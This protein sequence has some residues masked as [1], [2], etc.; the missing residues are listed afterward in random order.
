MSQ[1]NGAIYRLRLVSR[2]FW[3]ACILELFERLAYFGVRAIVPLYLVQARADRGLGLDFREKGIIFS[4]WALL[5]CTVP[6]VSGAL[7]D[8]YGHRKSLGVAFAFAAAGYVSMAQCEAIATR[9]SPAGGIG[10]VFVVFLVAASLVAIGTAIFKPAVQGTIAH[11]TPGE[12]SSLCW[13]VFYWIVNVGAA[14][15]PMC[16]AVLRSDTAWSNV[17]YAAA[18]VTGVNFLFALVFFQESI[19]LETRSRGCHR[20]PILRVVAASFHTI[21]RDK[22]LLF[23][24]AC[25]S[26]F[27]LMFMQVW[28]L[29][30]NFIN[31]WVDTSGLAPFYGWIHSGWVQANGQVK[32]ELIVNVNAISILLFVIPV[33]W[34]IAGFGKVRSMVLGMGLCVIGFVGCGTTP[35]GWLCCAMLFVFSV[36]EMI[37][38]PTFVAYIGLMA[39]P[40]NKALYM[41][42]SNIPFAVG[43]AL[44]SILGGT[45]YQ[46]HASKVE[47]ARRYLV[48]KVG[49]APG[50]VMNETKL[51]AS[52]VLGFLSSRLATDQAGVTRI[53]WESYDPWIV[54][55]YLAA[56][57][58]IATAG[59]AAFYVLVEKRNPVRVG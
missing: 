5:Q 47:L 41:G 35:V 37:C 10:P 7:A 32:P 49:L 9:L 36:G 1:P 53:L 21:L 29:L 50:F 14:M 33:S 28:D 44:G 23:F 56:I 13:G 20:S 46:E 3:V 34:A 45:L 19:A 6:M 57:G 22:R 42:Y 58:A 25:F 27:W 15:A 30:P 17:F 55:G 31:E 40:D 16:A 52:D 38:C 43:W 26:G 18:I 24:L 59:M 4:V 48:E 2:N 12:S 39:P 54:W 51:S 11:C 8:R